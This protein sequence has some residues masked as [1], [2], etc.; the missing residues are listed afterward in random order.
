[1]SGKSREIINSA[2]EIEIR[3]T[4]AAIRENPRRD[5]WGQ[6]MFDI[7]E[8]HIADCL[9]AMREL[10]AIPLSKPNNQGNPKAGD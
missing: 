2:L 9:A 10:A 8:A 6:P 1:M 5:H 7:R 3:A 4:K